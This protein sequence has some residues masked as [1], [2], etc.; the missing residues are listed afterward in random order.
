M[1]RRRRG[2]K[3]CRH[4]F[5]TIETVVAD[6]QRSWVDARVVIFTASQARGWRDAMRQMAELLGDA[7]DTP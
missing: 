4:R 6:S 2:C 5:T 1:M 7:S 3:A